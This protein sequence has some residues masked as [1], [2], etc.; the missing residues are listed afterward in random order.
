MCVRFASAVV[1]SASRV[2][3]NG[4]P[5]FFAANAAERVNM[6][7]L[8]LILAAVLGVLPAIADA[9]SSLLGGVTGAF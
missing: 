3:R 4:G 8:G 9:L 5:G 7:I 6:W 1:S 2:A